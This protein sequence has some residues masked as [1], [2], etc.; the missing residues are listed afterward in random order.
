MW[1][2]F[3]PHFTH[4][5]ARETALPFS[6]GGILQPGSYPH[7]SNNQ[8]AAGI[9]IDENA[10]IAFL[11]DGCASNSP[12]SRNEKSINEV[13]AN[14]GVLVAIGT[15]RRLLKRPTLI[16]QP[17][18]FV[19]L[20][21]ERYMKSLWHLTSHLAQT[22][23]FGKEMREHILFEFL[24]STILGVIV[25]NKHFL[26]L[27][28]GDGIVGINGEMKDMASEAGSY[29][30]ND[31]VLHIRQGSAPTFANAVKC[32]HAGPSSHLI[33]AM[34]A[35]DG[36]VNFPATPALHKMLSKQPLNHT[37]GFDRHFC[38]EF[39][40]DVA[41]A[42]ND[43]GFHDD[44]SLIVVRRVRKSSEEIKENLHA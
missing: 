5:H 18:T 28:R 32:I 8:D 19:N 43:E 12:F 29:P 11:S 44:R 16:S 21:S 6:V 1:S 10:I 38:R 27:G 40:A 37:P 35:S 31:L 39:R 36:F 42:V 14:I 20:F 34:L 30:L 15:A 25:T 3:V 13:G 22:R 23:V 33:Q 41:M 2:D 7:I 24:M 4:L 9:D 17:E 26:M